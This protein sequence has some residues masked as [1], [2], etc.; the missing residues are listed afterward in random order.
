[1]NRSHYGRGNTRSAR[2]LDESGMRAPAHF[3][4]GIE[5]VTMVV[6]TAPYPCVSILR[7]LH[8]LLFAL[9]LLRVSM[10]LYA[11][12][13]SSEADRARLRRV[14]QLL[15]SQFHRLGKRRTLNAGCLETKSHELS[16][17]SFAARDRTFWPLP[18]S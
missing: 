4:D 16:V 8:L 10:D 1:M 15:A 11:R 5:K 3:T 13:E 9:A 7:A 12:L 14:C 2:Y 17:S 18:R 6:F